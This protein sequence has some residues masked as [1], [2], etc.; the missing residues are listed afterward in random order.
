MPGPIRGTG[1]SRS[2]AAENAIISAVE[3]PDAYEDLPSTEGYVSMRKYRQRTADGMVEE[4]EYYWTKTKLD[5]YLKT[6]PKVPLFIPLDRERGQTNAKDA[7]PHPVFIDGI[8][9]NVPV[10]INVLVALPIARII[11]NMQAEYRTAQSQGLDLYT[12]NPDNPDDRGYEI[13][14]LGAV[15]G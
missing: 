3:I 13:P 15:A 5:A 2:A 4:P 9:I 10:G 8:R 14:A 7:P 11:E 6:C 12:I 1:A